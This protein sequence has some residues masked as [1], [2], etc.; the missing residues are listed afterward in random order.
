MVIL[1][2]LSHTLR[3]LSVDLMNVYNLKAHNITLLPNRVKNFNPI[4]PLKLN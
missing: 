2:S 3:N 1:K 4:Q